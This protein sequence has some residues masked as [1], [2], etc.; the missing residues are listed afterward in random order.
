MSDNVLQ[1][2]MLFQVLIPSTAKRKQLWRTME[3]QQFLL[4]QKPRVDLWG[5]GTWS[6][7]GA[8]PGQEDGQAVVSASTND[9]SAVTDVPSLLLLICFTWHCSVATEEQGRLQIGFLA[10]LTV[11]RWR[12]RT[13]IRPNSGSSDYNKSTGF[14][15]ES[16]EVVSPP[17]HSTLSLLLREPK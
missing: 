10:P 2:P 16:R 7:P 11:R 13:L 5:D 3:K 12:K 9:F 17:C 15:G 8:Q 14:R 6:R 4:L 1:M